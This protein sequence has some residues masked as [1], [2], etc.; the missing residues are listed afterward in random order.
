M[1]WMV[2]GP[3][4][5]W[6]SDRIGRRKPPMV[7]G[8]IGALISI[9]IFLYVPNMPLWLLGTDIFFLGFFSSGFLPAFSVIKESNPEYAQGTSLGFMNTLNSIGPA[10]AQLAIGILLDMLATRHI[11][12]GQMLYSS[13][14]YI[15]AL[16]I[17][18]VFIIIAIAL[19]PFIHETYC[20]SEHH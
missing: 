15:K 16:T 1:G 3:L 11:A 10:V 20:H 18:P 8:S 14:D 9:V 13:T 5:G 6:V 19:L 12:A 2:G 17:L 7:V 4:G